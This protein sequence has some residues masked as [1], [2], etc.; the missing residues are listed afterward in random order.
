ME[1][2]GHEPQRP[3]HKA[4]P[5]PKRLKEVFGARSGAEFPCTD[6]VP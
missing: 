6:D 2:H 4:Q 5:Q 3:L 1:R